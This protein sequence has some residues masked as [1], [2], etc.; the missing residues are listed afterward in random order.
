MVMEDAPVRRGPRGPYAKS[1]QTRKAILDAALNV[2]AESGFRSGSLRNVAERVGMSEAGLL[3][4]FPSKSAL[5]AA[6]LERRDEQT[7]DQFDLNPSSGQGMMSAFVKLAEYNAAHPGVVELFCTLSA[8]ATS[9]EHPAHDYFLQRYRYTTG[10]ITRAFEVIAGRDELRPG[11]EPATAARGTI[12][13][14]DGLQIQW[15]LDRDSVDMAADL[16][17]Y[18]NSLLKVEL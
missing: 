17:A 16:R 10:I 13:L 12:A 9:P 6:V 2:F 8:E 18:L 11:V 3:H 15:L 1:E 5:L 14:M 4:H 7:Q